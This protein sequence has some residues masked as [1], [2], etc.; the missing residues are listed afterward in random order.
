MSI[1]SPDSSLESLPSLTS[2]PSCSASSSPLPVTTD[3]P[4]CS[5]LSK[6]EYLLAQLR[7]KDAVIESLLKQL[8]NPYQA[9]PMS[10]ES[11]KRATS[12][13]DS[14][15]RNVL[16]WLSRLTSSIPKTNGK[17]G[18][19]AFLNHRTSQV[20]E[21]ESDQGDALQAVPMVP[22]DE[23][24]QDDKTD[25]RHSALPDSHVPIGMLA[26]L[27]LD[28]PKRKN[29]KSKNLEK[30]GDIDDIDVGVANALYFMPGP[31]TDLDARAQLIEQHSPPEIVLHGLV[32]PGDV[33]E[34]FQ[35]YAFLLAHWPFVSI[36]DPVLHTPASTF[37]RC[38]F[39]FT[40]I[41]AISTRYHPKKSGVYSIAMHF[42]KHSAAN[43]LVD[44]WKSVELC[45][46]YILMSIYAVPARRWE[47]DRS[48]L[49]T[50]LAIRLATDLNLHQQSLVKPQSERH[51]RE[52]L[53]RTR[54]WMICCNL[55]RSTAAQ[56]GKPST[57]KE[58]YTIRHAK[59]WYKKSKYNHQYDIHLCAYSELLR[60][61][62]K[63]H[64]EIFSDPSS[65]TGLNKKVNFLS[66]TFAHDEQLVSFQEEWSRRFY[67][68]S[69]KNDKGCAFR[70]SLMPYLVGYSRLV[71]FSFG[72][73]HAFRP[74]SQLDD[75]C[76][77]SAK[78]IIKDMIEG[79]VPSGY[80][81][82]A[83]DGHF[84]FASFASAFLLKLLRPEFSKLLSTNEE[85]EILELISRLIQTLSSPKIALDDK[86]TPK[87]YA[88]FLAGLL[89]R[90]RR[91]SSAR[92][93]T[94]TSSSNSAPPPSAPAIS[95]QAPE[96]SVQTQ[97]QNDVE[98][99][100]TNGQHLGLFQE[101]V[102]PSVYTP[103]TAIMCDS[104]IDMN[105]DFLMENGLL[106]DE[107]LLATMQIL[108]SPAWWQN[109]MMPGYV[110]PLYM[111]DREF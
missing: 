106:S 12:P 107:E 32:T 82:Y 69:D 59:Y 35:L 54:V 100:T 105:N 49:Y 39:L 80:M 10:I 7:Q 17:I 53:N 104:V 48:W 21:E 90:H 95:V 51:E 83:P 22:G 29:R 36:L 67:R 33:E 45:Q 61:I 97:I 70:C 31:A 76:L 15:N 81:G 98:H 6:R 38:P 78:A 72:F 19:N 41:C 25:E 103:E 99:L 84:I 34:L 110:F 77:S 94:T 55:D 96:E 91:D 63:F 74:G 18:A 42:A 27:S 92:Q 102:A 58:H 66:V 47:E 37:S 13:S 44:G 85:I 16:E 88:R 108:K 1:P 71:M 11:Y 26:D 8:H 65:P 5:C 28:K 30:E 56:F 87:L 2:T 86:H 89:S 46:A 20:V 3:L 101:A 79:L 43:A 75:D 14:S 50:G 23:S 24:G 68:E 57:I 93:H 64:D 109:M 9:T 4:C 73:Q 52:I 62:A 111:G 40:V 60:I